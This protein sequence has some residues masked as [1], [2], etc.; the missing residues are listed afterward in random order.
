MVE[1]GDYERVYL[2]RSWK[3]ATGEATASSEIPDV[4]GIR[5]DGKV[6]VFEVRSDS[7]KQRQLNQKSREA[8]KLLPANRRGR[9]RTLE[10]E[11]PTN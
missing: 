3:T 6:D 2:Q 11:P 5:R 10:P 1:T 8:L 9:F 7:Q 4:I